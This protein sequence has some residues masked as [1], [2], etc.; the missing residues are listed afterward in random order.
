[1]PPLSLC[2][3]LN[4]PRLLSHSSQP[5]PPDPSPSL[6]PSF[7]HPLIA[8][9]PFCTAAPKTVQKGSPNTKCPQSVGL[10]CAEL[11]GASLSGRVPHY[12]Q[13]QAHCFSLQMASMFS[14]LTT[15]RARGLHTGKGAC[16]PKPIAVQQ[17]KKDRP[18]TPPGISGGFLMQYVGRIFVP[19]FALS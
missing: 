17:Q 3:G 2:S 15:R 8:L 1:M 11:S 5:S 10:C 13:G 9:C 7:G 12:Q 19:G 4:K 16:F 18:R 6:Q 14:L